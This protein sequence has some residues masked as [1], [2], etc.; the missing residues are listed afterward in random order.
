MIRRLLRAL[1]RRR[2]ALDVPTIRLRLP[3]PTHHQAPAEPLPGL[4]PDFAPHAPAA[5]EQRARAW[6]RN[7]LDL[8]GPK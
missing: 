5:D 4:P 3:G 7:R 8:G 2:R 1:R 6:L